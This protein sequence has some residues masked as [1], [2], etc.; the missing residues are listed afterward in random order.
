MQTNAA[1]IKKMEIISMLS[2]IPD[3]KLDSIREYIDSILMESNSNT[4]SNHSLE[5]IWGGKGFERI[6]DLKSEI[7]ETRKQL[8]DEILK[9][10]L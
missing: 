9:R 1:A 10:Q 3:N 2:L 6:A 8:N 7:K 5:G 4:K